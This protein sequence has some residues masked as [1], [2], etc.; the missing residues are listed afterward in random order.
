MHAL[1][2][3]EDA[4]GYRFAIQ[5]FQKP[6][7]VQ[8][9]L[10]RIVDEERHE[11]AGLA[12]RLLVFVK[13]VMHLPEMGGILQAGRLGSLGGDQSMLVRWDQ[14][15]FAKNNAQVVSELGFDF[16]K[17]RVVVAA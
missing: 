11:I 6:I 17:F 8:P 7:S 4:S 3:L 13:L 1:A 14:W 2:V 12:P 16:L 5:I 9:D 10:F 15:P